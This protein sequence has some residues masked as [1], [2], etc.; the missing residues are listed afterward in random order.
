MTTTFRTSGAWGAGKGSNLTPAE[1]DNN[2]YDKETRIAALEGAGVGVGIDT[3]TVSGNQMTITLTDS[4]VQG[5]FTLPTA[6]WQPKGE[7]QPSTVYYAYDVVTYLGSGFLV[8]LDHTSDSTFDAGATDGSLE[9]Y[10][11]LWSVAAPQGQQ[12]SDSAFTP[13]LVDAGIYTR[14]TNPGGCTVT[15]DSTVEFDPWTELHFRDESESGGVT[16]T[17][18]GTTLNI[19][20]GFTA[21]SAGIGATITVK[22]VDATNEWDVMGRLAAA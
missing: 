5:P 9:I 14:L 2:F 13:Q 12:I 17:T 21:V 19:P 18:S 1:V 20:A 16:I 10:T 8:N 6:A 11:R 15:I 4:S 3:I 7:W 22:K